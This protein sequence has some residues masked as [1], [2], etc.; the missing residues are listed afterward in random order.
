MSEKFYEMTPNNNL[1]IQNAT[2]LIPESENEEVKGDNNI[3]LETKSIVN[4]ISIRVGYS[5]GMFIIFIIVLAPC[6]LMYFYMFLPGLK[7]LY[8]FIYITL[9][10]FSP[11]IILIFIGMQKENK[12]RLI[13]NE[14]NNTLTLKVINGFYFPKHTFTF[15][16][17]G[18]VLD[19]IEQLRNSENDE[20]YYT[21]RQLVISNTFKY[22]SETDLNINKIK[23]KP[24]NNI[25]YIIKDTKKFDERYSLLKDFL[26]ISSENESP[27]LFNINK[28]MGKSNTF[29]YKSNDNLSRYMK[30]SDNFFSF[31]FEKSCYSTS[32]LTLIQFTTYMSMFVFLFGIMPHKEFIKAP[33]GAYLLLLTIMCIIPVI[34][35]I[36]II[37]KI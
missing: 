4:E 28:Y 30:M 5:I 21:V 15:N 2:P 13:K 1:E 34:I 23:D 14:I 26:N 36:I 27:V 3:K 37:Y 20:G 32:K 18:V 8:T 19:S 29:S 10:F 7:D 12:I 17:K 33:I 9:L 25:Y 24:I 6:M 35:T 11:I 22:C 16:L 31:Y